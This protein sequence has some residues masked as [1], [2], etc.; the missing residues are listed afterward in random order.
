MYNMS[1][2][3][4]TAFTTEIL[5]HGAVDGVTGSCHELVVSHQ[6]PNPLVDSYL[7]DCGLFQGAETVGR[8]AR[9]LLAIN[10]PLAS[11]RALLVTHCHI[12]HVG[13]IPYL[14]AAGFSGPIFCSVATARLLPEVIADALKVGGMHGKG[15]GKAVL[16]RLKSQLVAVEYGQWCGLPVHRP[17]KAGDV[18]TEPPANVSSLII[19]ARFK[20]AGHILG[21][22]YIEFDLSSPTHRER[23]VFSGDL[24]ACYTP[25]LPAPVP[26]YRCDKLIIESTYGDRV[27]QGRK[28]RRAQLELVL[29]KCLDDNGV[30]LIP[31]FSI[32]RTQELLY[33]IEEILHRIKVKA[34]RSNIESVINN[35]DVIVDSP[36]AAK[37]TSHYGELKHCWDKE[38]RRKIRQ[39]R[40]PLSFEQLI[41]I[42][43][44]RQHLQ[45][46]DYLANRKVPAIVIAASGMCSGGRIVNYLKRFIENSTTDVLF[47]GYQARGTL[48]R[49]II[50]YGMAGGYV[51]IDRKRYTIRAKIYRLDGYSAHADK[52]DL[53]RFVKRMRYKPKEIRLVHGDVGAKA[54]LRAALLELVPDCQVNIGHAA[55]S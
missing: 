53:I 47:V 6:D 3:N 1:L 4:L 12:D 25:L 9:E 22:A 11:I 13:R 17:P 38:A 7:I 23:V 55:D 30:V 37:F 36:L 50:K 14:L 40:H 5:H 49:A 45:V 21:S 16:R 52:K 43:S 15:I 10:F 18:A 24:G 32:G 44:H 42:A 8:S 28:A 41:T 20:P 51:E 27:H 29:K 39:G 31:A 54:A 35:I 46:L 33:E 48:G 26:P 2:L 19:K 34:N